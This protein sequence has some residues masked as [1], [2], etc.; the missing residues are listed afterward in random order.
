MLV[1]NAVN[2]MLELR[3]LAVGG[4]GRDKGLLAM[5]ST[6]PVGFLATKRLESGMNYTLRS[7]I[8]TTR[9]CLNERRP[10]GLLA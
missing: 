8:S 4:T 10:L 6:E 2:P 5:H 3:P 1:Q 7:Y 9:I